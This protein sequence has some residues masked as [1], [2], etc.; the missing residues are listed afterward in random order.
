M[1]RGIKFVVRKK[2]YEEKKASN[3]WKFTRMAFFK[4]KIEKVSY[5][6]YKIL[7]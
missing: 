7:S 1:Q 4:D 5:I 3:N 6:S 2:V